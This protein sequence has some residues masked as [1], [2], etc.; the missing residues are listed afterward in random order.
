MSNPFVG[1][2]RLV[3]FNF[4]PVSWNSCNG[5]LLPISEYPALYNLIGTTY[6]GDGQSTFG[7]PD[8]RSR[9]TI[10]Q[11][12]NGTNTYV[13]GATGGV[14][15]VTLS[16]SQYPH[17]NHSLLASNSPGGSN[18]PVSNVVANL[19]KV[20]SGVTPATPM[21]AAMLAP[22]GGGS[23]P[24]ENRQ[25]YQALNWIIALFGIYPSQG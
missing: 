11:G 7:V 13:M 4:A 8:L 21:N 25:P 12:P 3:G 1:E 19:A 24:H 17:H 9:I 2:V 16:V 23:Q 20:Y 6:G 5:A 22:S 15:S 14:E 18:S 10:H